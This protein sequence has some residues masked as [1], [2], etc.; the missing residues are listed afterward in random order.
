MNK[1]VQ[2]IALFFI[3]VGIISCK[4]KLTKPEIISEKILFENIELCDKSTFDYFYKNY[5]LMKKINS[6]TLILKK[7]K[8]R[9]YLGTIGGLEFDKSLINPNVFPTW[10]KGHLFAPCN[11]PLDAFTSKN[12]IYD[13]E[14]DCIFYQWD[15]TS[16]P[17]DFWPIAFTRLKILNKTEIPK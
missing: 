2:Y 17:I 7:V 12:L 10:G 13:I 8:G 15:L 6:D 16:R 3:F 14:F 9:F 11:T 4:K 1:L 5:G